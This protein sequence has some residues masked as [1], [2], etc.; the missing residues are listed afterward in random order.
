M[1]DVLIVIPAYNEEKNIINVINDI[2]N[3]IK[4]ADVIV[5]N[6]NST[7][8]TEEILKKS[9]I[10]YISLPFNMGYSSAL[11]CGFKYATKNNYKYIIQFDGDGQ[12]KATEAK[13]LYDVIL[14][15]SADVVIGSR[16]KEKSSYKHSFFR[17]IGTKLFSS[18]IYLTC[19][20]KISDPTT[21]L[22]ILSRN[23]FVKYSQMG[24]YPEY[25]DANLLIEMIYSRFTISEVQVEMSERLF[26]ESMHS[27][28]IKP[29]KYIIKMLYSILIVY[30][31]YN[32]SREAAH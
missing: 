10:N 27:G 24:S 5:I 17:N 22:Q 19:K 32:K 8:G 2:Y 13:K 11:Q 23:V 20:T 4:F 31:K 3:H 1:N 12:H 18:L 9:N 15:T 16:F 29:I 21:G 14:A 28:I 6:D 25:P 30:L 7:D 26:G